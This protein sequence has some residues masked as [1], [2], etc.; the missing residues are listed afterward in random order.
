M[1]GDVTVETVIYIAVSGVSV[2]LLW[3]LGLQ[4]VLR[5][6]WNTQRAKQYSPRSRRMN[7]VDHFP[8]APPDTAR[9]REVIETE[10]RTRLV[11][12]EQEITLAGQS[13]SPASDLAALGRSRRRTPP[14]SGL[15][16]AGPEEE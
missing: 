1:L 14:K 4:P 12:G 11:Q 10:I 5:K 16:L 7:T 9:V 13:S 15:H 3:L 8:E 2:T 6:L